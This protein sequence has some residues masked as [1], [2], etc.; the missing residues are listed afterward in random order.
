M[1][2]IT[3]LIVII[4]LFVNGYSQNIKRDTI[5][6]KKAL[7]VDGDFIYH[8]TVLDF[9]AG[10]DPT[11]I[12]SDPN[13]KKDSLL[14]LTAARTWNAS[15]AKTIDAADITYW[16]RP[17]RDSIFVADSSGIKERLRNLET[18]SGEKNIW[19]ITLPS[20]SSVAGRIALA[21][22]YPAGWTLTANGVNL[23]VTHNLARWCT[24]VKV[25]S[26]INGTQRQ[27]LRLSAAENGLTALS[28]NQAEVYS[29][30]T[31]AKDIVVY[32]YFE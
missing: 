1:K 18:L 29:L 21:T 7:A 32:L 23:V 3:I 5:T 27:Q 4:L 14:L 30:S 31:I 16:G 25:F 2:H 15:L 11:V 8:G 13:Y 6:S 12:E 22:D 26:I 19:H 20:A 10:S 9:S 17:E 28:A 24:D